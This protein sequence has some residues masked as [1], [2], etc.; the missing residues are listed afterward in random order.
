MTA[1]YR[2]IA[3]QNNQSC[4]VLCHYGWLKALEGSGAQLICCY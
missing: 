4:H 2:Y 3:L 1:L